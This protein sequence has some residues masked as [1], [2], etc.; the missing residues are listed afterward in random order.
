[1]AVNREVLVPHVQISESVDLGQKSSEVYGSAGVRRPDK[2]ALL[3]ILKGRFLADITAIRVHNGAEHPT[4][5][6]DHRASSH[7]LPNDTLSAEGRAGVRTWNEKSRASRGQ[8]FFPNAR[9][10]ADKFHVLR[11]LSPHI[12]RR[13][14]LIEG[15]R[16]SAALR[17]LLLRSRFRLEHAE[18]FA[19]DQWLAGHPELRALYDAKEA[20]HS[21]YRIRG[22]DR[23]AHAMTVLT[24][25]LAASPLPELQTLSRTLMRWRRE[26]LAY[27]GTGL[28][29][30]RTEGFNNKAL[31]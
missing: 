14:R 19:L 26:I 1:M 6:L 21:L 3:V 17:Q 22:R 29:N 11:L 4:F 24:D 8:R 30:G 15:D 28:T 23:A 18:R 31:E 5:V 13:R 16:R 12:N 10:V 25:R 7:S 27:F 20:M 9:L 2:I